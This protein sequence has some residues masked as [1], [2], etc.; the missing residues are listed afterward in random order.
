MARTNL[1]V[2][3][4]IAIDFYDDGNSNKGSI[5]LDNRQWC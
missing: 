4:G 5:Y 1:K 3:D 2:T